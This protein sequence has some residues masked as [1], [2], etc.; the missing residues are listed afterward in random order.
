M[1]KKIKY[2][3]LLSIC[4]LLRISPCGKQ[5]SNTYIYPGAQ[6]NTAFSSVHHVQETPDRI[7]TNPTLGGGGV[8]S[9]TDTGSRIIIAGNGIVT[10]TSDSMVRLDANGL[11]KT[12][13]VAETDLGI[14]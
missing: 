6:D 2:F 5:F 14:D 1:F 9:V 13:M 7:L 3:L 4:S 11:T 10:D 8:I 12:V